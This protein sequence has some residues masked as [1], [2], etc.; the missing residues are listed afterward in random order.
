MARLSRAAFAA[1]PETQQ[2]LSKDPSKHERQI[3]YLYHI[4]YNSLPAPAPPATPRPAKADK[5]SYAA[6]LRAGLGARNTPSPASVTAQ[7]QELRS[8]RQQISALTAAL[9]AKDATIHTLTKSL[10]SSQATTA[11]FERA[12]HQEQLE[13]NAADARYKAATRKAEAKRLKVHAHNT[14]YV[15]ELKDSL[16]QLRAY[17]STLTPRNPPACTTCDRL[18]ADKV[19]LTAKLARSF[20]LPELTRV[21]SLGGMFSY[22]RAFTGLPRRTETTFRLPYVA[23]SAFAPLRNALPNRPALIKFYTEGRNTPFFS[24]NLDDG[25]CRYTPLQ[26][27][28]REISPDLSHSALAVFNYLDAVL[29]IHA[30][31]H[32]P[33][34]RS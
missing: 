15:A 31:A 11:R 16:K 32:S 3:R 18:A 14:A 27:R 20:T 24:I 4:Y 6:A 1:L 28:E 10:A 8:A 23:R 19:D 22:R 5:P 34:G 12:L 30:P 21:P 13:H 25:T 7:L 2:R 33:P 26:W 17:G 9:R 29:S